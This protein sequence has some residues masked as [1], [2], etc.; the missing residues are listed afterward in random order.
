MTGVCCRPRGSAIAPLGSID[1]DYPIQRALSRGR[2]APF[3]GGDEAARTS[4]NCP[5]FARVN[6]IASR[7]CVT[8]IVT[9]EL[10]NFRRSMVLLN[11][12]L[13]RA[14]Y[15]VKSPDPGKTPQM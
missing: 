6:A 8:C 12:L 14:C 11:R 15:L 5:A 3:L 7:P 10:M 4:K 2:T 9:Q 13:A 1:A